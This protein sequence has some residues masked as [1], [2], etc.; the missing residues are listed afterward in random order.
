METHETLGFIFSSIFLAGLIWMIVR[1]TKMKLSEFRALVIMLV[2]A[3][4]LLGYSAHLGGTMVYKEGAGVEPM[5]SILQDEDHHH[6]QE[7]EDADEHHDS[8]HQEDE[9]HDDDHSSTHEH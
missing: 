1:K 7:G 3:S 5:K 2:V 6:H 4:G 8:D 9:H